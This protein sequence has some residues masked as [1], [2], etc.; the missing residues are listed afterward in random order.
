METWRCHIRQI[1]LSAKVED[2]SPL[3]NSTL[4]FLC[5]GRHIRKVFPKSNNARVLVFYYERKRGA[6]LR[7]YGGGGGGGDIGLQVA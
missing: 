3:A 4:C 6:S 7:S 1:R 5:L 2:G